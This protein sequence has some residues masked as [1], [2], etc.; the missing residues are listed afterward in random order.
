MK[1]DAKSKLLL[2]MLLAATFIV[3][4]NG[5]TR[6]EDPP[7]NVCPPL[8]KLHVTS[9]FGYRIH[10]LTGKKKFHSG[11]D[12]AARNDTVFAIL[13]AAVEA[14]GRSPSLGRFIRLK[15]DSLT[16]IYSHLRTIAVTAG[17]QLSPGDPIAITGSTGLVTGEHLHLAILYRG[18][19]IHP[20]RF[21]RRL[22][23]RH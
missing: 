20:L 10:P 18:I 13:E 3:V 4:C 23:Y 5:I 7:L 22:A 17:Q 2:P 8:K 9:T 14:T 11:I 19:Y 12:L 16:V 6:A 15:Q 1:K 21:I